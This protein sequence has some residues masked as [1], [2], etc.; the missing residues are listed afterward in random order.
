MHRKHAITYIT[1]CASTDFMLSD[2]HYYYSMINTLNLD[3]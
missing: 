1:L 2:A 3:H